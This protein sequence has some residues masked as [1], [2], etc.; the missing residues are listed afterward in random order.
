MLIP[1]TL[2][3]FA[4]RIGVKGAIIAALVLALGWQTARIEGFA[5]WPVKITGLKADLAA[6]ERD[7]ADLVAASAEA[8]ERAVQAR[9][10]Q[11]A[12]FQIIAEKADVQLEEARRDALADARAFIDRN[13]VHQNGLRGGG[14]IAPASDRDPGSGLQAGPAPEL[15]GFV[16]VPESDVL[17]CTDTTLRLEAVQAW[18]AGLNAPQ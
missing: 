4:T 3:T 2:L 9:M 12:R 6:C 10:A 17:I 14:T 5:I 7:K 11:Q 13:R 8:H 1:P 15:D 18:A 16:A